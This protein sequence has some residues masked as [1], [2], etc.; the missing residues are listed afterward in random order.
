MNILESQ[1]KKFDE[2]FYFGVNCERHWADCPDKPCRCDEDKALKEK[3]K[4]IKQFLTNFYH[5]IRKA[6]RD[7][8]KR[9]MEKEKKAMHDV[10]TFKY[11]EIY[12]ELIK[13][14]K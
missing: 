7:K 6:E 5:K 10:G 4:Q 9:K 11:D 1:L 2:E 14:I 3:E 13:Q 8:I 12:D